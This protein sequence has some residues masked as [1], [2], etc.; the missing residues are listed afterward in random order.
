MLGLLLVTLPLALAAESEVLNICM[1]GTHQKVKPGPEGQLFKQ[2]EPWRDN[3]CC[4]ANTS[5][6]AHN[7][8]SHLY[9]FNWNHC[10]IMTEKCKRHFI[11][12]TCFYECSPNL[13]PWIQQVSSS[14]RDE[15][16][17][18]V[19]ICKTDCDEWWR[20]CQ[21]DYTCKEDWHYGWDWSTGINQCPVGSECR[22]FGDVFPTARDLCEKVWSNSYRW[23]DHPRGSGLC[24]SL[25]F[26]AGLKPNPNQGVA[27]HYALQMG[28]ISCSSLAWPSPL[29]LGLSLLLSPS[30][31]PSLSP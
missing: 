9:N 23:T 28:L 1:N 21:Q 10:G 18:Y 20:D 26:K 19:P 31:S 12:D 25:W 30:L 2:C 13:G 11:Q 3:A 22:R 5:V 27:R 17:L 16:I 29:L 7:D 6:H 15:R 14:W 8:Q 24:M 4:T